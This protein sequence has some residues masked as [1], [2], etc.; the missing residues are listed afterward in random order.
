MPGLFETTTLNG[1]ELKNRFVRSATYEA[2]AE[3]DGRV[4]DQLCTYMADLSSGTI[5]LIIT[6]HAHVTMEGQAGP[7]QVGIYCD[8]MVDGLKKM[9]SAVH[10][11]GGVIALQ[12]GHAGKKGIGKDEYAPRGATD[13]FEAGIK[14]VTAMTVNDIKRTVLAF[15]D[16]AAR[17]V[18][19]GFDAIQIH[20]AHGYLL[21]Q[22]LSP[23]YN[24]RNDSYSGNLQ[25]R[26]RFLLEVY[27]EAAVPECS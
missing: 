12:L 7:R 25:N 4:T 1:I 10:T 6:G 18:K 14:T 3:L 15:G 20:A 27:Q 17:A 5:G 21:S 9:T 16:A 8:E 2:M 23:H 11:N 26:A 24:K 13:V 22:F 19:A